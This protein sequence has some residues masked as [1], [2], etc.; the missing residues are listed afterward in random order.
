MVVI[1]LSRLFLGLASFDLGFVPGCEDMDMGVA[2]LLTKA[3]G[4]YFTELGEPVS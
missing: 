4:G 2:S 3:H 1:F